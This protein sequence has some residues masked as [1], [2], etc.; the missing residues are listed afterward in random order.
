MAVATANAS[1][2]VAAPPFSYVLARREAA[3][4]LPETAFACA[5]IEGDL[6]F[7]HTRDLDIGV[8][9]AL[10]GAFRVLIF[11]LVMDVAARSASN[12]VI[13]AGLARAIESSFESFLDALD[14]LAGRFVVVFKRPGGE[15][16]SICSD[17]TGM[18]KVNYHE[19]TRACSSNIFLLRRIAASEIAYRPE[20][21]GASRT[22]WKFGALGN[23]SP[24]QGCKILT[25]NH[26]LNIATGEIVRFFP[27]A[28]LPTRSM[29]AIASEFREICD[30]QV[31]ALSEKFRL[32]HSLSA[33]I[34]SRFSLA[35]ASSRLKE[36]IFFTYLENESH[37]VDFVVSGEIAKALGLNHHGVIVAP[38]EKFQAQIDS[39]PSPIV[40][41]DLPKYGGTVDTIREWSWYRHIPRLALAYRTLIANT[42]QGSVRPP[43]HI[44]SSLYEIV[45]GRRG[46]R[47][48]CRDDSSILE[49]SRLDWAND[50]LAAAIFAAFFE[51]SKLQ[52]AFLF[53][54]DQLDMFYWEH[55]CGTWVS[56]VLGETDF[57]FN[58]HILVN[59]RRLLMLLLSLDF[60]ER[61]AASFFLDT[62]DKA[63]PSIRDIPINPTPESLGLGA[64]LSRHADAAAQAAVGA[65]RAR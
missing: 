15:G 47:G 54:Y 31:S 48:P 5:A 9:R 17:A 60:E 22:L 35:L 14:D 32:Y 23:L 25:P 24:L 27:R 10:D 50:E 65:A 18:L 33:G 63:L 19:E 61:V 55:R 13:A 58:S 41:P 26:Y 46:S 39:Y 52:S 34:D 53:G 20:F 49:Q 16:V 2:S 44:R 36:V 38:T 51:E 4:A 3:L 42:Q 45:R 29:A 57:A 56:E 1:P 6:R 21:E 62:I 37:L 12:Q 11:G 59:C 8:A 28:P 64:A 7:F 30:F 43:L 40:Y